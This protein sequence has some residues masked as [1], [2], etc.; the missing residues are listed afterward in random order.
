ML[1]D[2]NRHSALT[3]PL[4]NSYL[5]QPA[6]G[7]PY[8]RFSQSFYNVELT[9]SKPSSCSIRYPVDFIHSSPKAFMI[10]GRDVDTS[11]L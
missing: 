1:Q 10:K 6:S 5:P 7:P 9:S 11:K 3:P 8:L 2:Y 4:S